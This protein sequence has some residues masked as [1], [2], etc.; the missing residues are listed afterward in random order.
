MELTNH[1]RLAVLSEFDAHFR[2]GSRST[3][4]LPNWLPRLLVREP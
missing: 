3:P 1:T 2:Y 4:D